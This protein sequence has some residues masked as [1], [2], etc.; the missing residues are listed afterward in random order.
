M[1]GNRKAPRLTPT[2]SALP[3]EWTGSEIV[4]DL[5]PAADGTELRFTHIGLVP[6]VECFDACTTGWHHY[7]NGS[8][9]RLITTGAGLPDP[10]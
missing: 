3:A 9:R 8:L 4:F 2:G 5:V 10:W 7:I 1:G 6:D